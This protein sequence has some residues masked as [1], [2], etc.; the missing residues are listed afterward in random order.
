VVSIDG[1]A[2]ENY[3]EMIAAI[4]A[5]KPGDQVTLKV[6]RGGSETTITATL[7]QRPAG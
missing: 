1:K 2:I 7:T 6:V 4:R 3:S 5:H